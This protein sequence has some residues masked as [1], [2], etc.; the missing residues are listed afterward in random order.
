M[1]TLNITFRH[2]TPA[3]LAS[4]VLLSRREARVQRRAGNVYGRAVFL[5]IALEA[6]RALREQVQSGVRVAEVPKNQP[7]N[8]RNVFHRGAVR[9][10]A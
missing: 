10:I 1:P 4:I 5:R 2:Q 9:R 6:R 7:E 3:S 8:F